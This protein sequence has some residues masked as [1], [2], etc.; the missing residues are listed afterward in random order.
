MAGNGRHATVQQRDR[1]RS[2]LCRP[3]NVAGRKTGLQPGPRPEPR[4]FPVSREVIVAVMLARQCWIKKRSHSLR[5][6]RPV[7]VVKVQADMRARKL[8]KH[9]HESSLTYVGRGRSASGETGAG[10]HTRR[11][12]QRQG[13]NVGSH[14]HGCSP[15]NLG[16]F[17]SRVRPSC[18][19]FIK[20]V[21]TL[22]YS[23]ALIL[24]DQE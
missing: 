22:C 6:S 14:S 15:G 1:R 17:R 8:Q 12:C 16:S 21:R 5:L 13:C 20:R 23:S 19:G 2:A 4:E 11:D 18:P 24:A 9:W 10:R 3:S 7:S